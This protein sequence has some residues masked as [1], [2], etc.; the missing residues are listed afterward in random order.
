[1]Y[2]NTGYGC[3]KKIESAD[4]PKSKERISRISGHYAV[5]AKRA[6]RRGRRGILTK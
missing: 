6:C 4:R 1:M 2:R 3:S 5:G